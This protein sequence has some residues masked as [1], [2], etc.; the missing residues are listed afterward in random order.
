VTTIPLAVGTP[1]RHLGQQWAREATATITDV[2][3]PYNDGSYE[4]EVLA[5]ADFSRRLGDSNPQ[6]RTTWWPS[7]AT[8]RV[9]KEQQ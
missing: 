9:P 6:T 8:I 2:K 1:V 4:Y 5:G 7:W 3:G